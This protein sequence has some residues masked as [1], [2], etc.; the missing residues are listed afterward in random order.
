MVK[1]WIVGFLNCSNLSALHC[2]GLLNAASCSGTAG[3]GFARCNLDI[4][5][6]ISRQVCKKILHQVSYWPWKELIK[7]R[8]VLIQI[9]LIFF[10]FIILLVTCT[11]NKPILLFHKHIV[12][13]FI[14]S[15]L[16]SSGQP[17]RHLLTTGWSLFVSGKRLLAGDSVL[18]I[19]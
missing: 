5:S 11:H 15:F 18:F 7:V 17:K 4:P 1:S 16:P 12:S 8:L 14:K 6:Y 19:R 10:N 3:Q 2:T 9:S 13:Y